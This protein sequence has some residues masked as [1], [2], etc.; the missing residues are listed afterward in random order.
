MSDTCVGRSAGALPEK[1]AARAAPPAAATKIATMRRTA[2]RSEIRGSNARF[3]EVWASREFLVERC[4]LP[5]IYEA[6]SLV[7]PVQAAP[8]SGV[9]GPCR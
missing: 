6:T 8:G 7:P 9:W 3:W 2:V 5:L 1:S 4:T